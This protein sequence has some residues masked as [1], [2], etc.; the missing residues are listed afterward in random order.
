MDL[1]IIPVLLR[2]ARQFCGVSIAKQ[3]EIWQRVYTAFM[4]FGY[5]P[6]KCYFKTAENHGQL[7]I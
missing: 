4:T 7:A 2:L 3:K 1:L 6:I 5:S